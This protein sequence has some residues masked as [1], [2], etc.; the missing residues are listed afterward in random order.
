MAADLDAYRGIYDEQLA[1][2]PGAQSLTSTRISVSRAPAAT[3]AAMSAAVTASGTAEDL[4]Q[5][6]RNR[7]HR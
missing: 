7:G 6:L 2:L 3:S 5:R 1:T 4:T